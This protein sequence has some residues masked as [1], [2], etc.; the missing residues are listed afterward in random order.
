MPQNKDT[1]YGFGDINLNESY[2]ANMLYEHGNWEAE[3]FGDNT[4]EQEKLERR[5]QSHNVYISC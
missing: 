5:I 3:D 2:F 4:E 1:R